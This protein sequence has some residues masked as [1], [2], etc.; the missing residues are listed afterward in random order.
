MGNHDI[1]TLEEPTWLELTNYQKPYYY[2][3]VKG[4]RII[5]LN[6]NYFPD[7]RETDHFH[8]CF[9]G[10]LGEEQFKWLEQTLKNAVYKDKDPVV[11]IHQPPVKTDTQPRWQLF[12]QG[13]ELHKLFAKYGVRNVFSGHIERFC[14]FKGQQKN[15]PE[16]FVLQ[17]TWKYKYSL[18]EQNQ[19]KNAGNCY[20]ITVTP[21]GTEVKTEYRIFKERNPLSKI[22]IHWKDLVDHWEQTIITPEKYNCEDFSQLVNP[23]EEDIELEEE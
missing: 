23:E 17:G 15:Q 16:Y 3:D 6:G 5:V 1:R 8:R 22:K 21:Q 20:Y 18:K 19:F 2:L 4:Y 10:G 12:P 13:E 7:G 9:S 11:F 14:D